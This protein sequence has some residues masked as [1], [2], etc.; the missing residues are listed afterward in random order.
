M[1]GQGVMT[2]G[3]S[4]ETIFAA[5]QAQYYEVLRFK[6][7]TTRFVDSE[8]RLTPETSQFLLDALTNDSSDRLHHLIHF[9]HDGNSV[10]VGNLFRDA[11]DNS[12]IQQIQFLLDKTSPQIKTDNA[13]ALVSGAEA[14][15]VRELDSILAEAG[16]Q[17]QE[18]LLQQF[19]TARHQVTDTNGDLTKEGR[20]LLQEVLA[21][22]PTRSIRFTNQL[23]GNPDRF[24]DAV[25][26]ILDNWKER[27]S[28]LLGMIDYATPSTL[29][30]TQ[31]KDFG[32]ALAPEMAGVHHD[33]TQQFERRA[34]VLNNLTQLL[35]PKR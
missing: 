7:K 11:V 5:V 32:L 21:F 2:Q 18:A 6:E 19:A 30:Q 25:I 12:N 22:D 14:V 1:Y 4:P 27:G 20:A 35:Q 33:K 17:R 24:G 8:G 10:K 26:N 13:Y 34:R 15:L 23:N 16:L 9:V 3:E 29:A 28:D 31:F